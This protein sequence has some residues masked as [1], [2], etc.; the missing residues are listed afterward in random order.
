MTTE[1]TINLL[2]AHVR[3]QISQVSQ[4]SQDTV[5][6]SELCHQGGQSVCLVFFFGLQG[7][8]GKLTTAEFIRVKVTFLFL[9]KWCE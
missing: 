2:L 4:V 6:S 9:A 1:P 7:S 5:G 3:F 8:L